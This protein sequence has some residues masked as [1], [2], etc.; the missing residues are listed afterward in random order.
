MPL[1]L[2]SVATVN[3]FLKDKGPKI[4][5]GVLRTSELA[6]YLKDRNMPLR[7]SLSED[8]TRITPKVSYDN[9]TNQLVGFAR[10][11]DSNGMP[12]RS[13]FDAKNAKQIQSH[14]INPA[15]FVSSNVI[16]QMVQPQSSTVS[17]F[18]LNLFLTDNRY[19]SEK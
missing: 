6:K 4:V 10:P 2:P 17:P 9:N 8:A 19:C 12:I 18:C 11:L 14:F 15:N 16:V 5:E 7:F 3:R 1:S 13:V